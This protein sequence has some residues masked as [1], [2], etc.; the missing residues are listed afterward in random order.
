MIL[1]TLVLLFNTGVAGAFTKRTPLY[2]WSFAAGLVVPIP[3]FPPYG[4]S[5][6]LFVVPAD[7]M[8]WFPDDAAMG[9]AKV[10]VADV[11][12]TMMLPV[13]ERL[14][15][16]EVANT[17]VAMA[18]RTLMARARVVERDRFLDIKFFMLL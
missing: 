14:V 7:E 16:R 15:P 12:D 9:A 3:T 6:R 8:I 17:E 4:L 2:I 10:E 5:R 18:R 13:T 11:E 1:L